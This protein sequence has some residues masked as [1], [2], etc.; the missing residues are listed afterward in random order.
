VKNEPVDKSS[1]QPV[2]AENGIPLGKLK[3]GS[4]EKTAFL[5]AKVRKI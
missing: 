1:S 3:A 5:I 2:I 4:D